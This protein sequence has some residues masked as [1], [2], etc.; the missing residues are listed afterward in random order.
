ISIEEQSFHVKNK[1]ELLCKVPENV[2]DF[3]RESIHDPF[4][5]PLYAYDI[6][7]YYKERESEFKLKKYMECQPDLS[8]SMRAILIDWMVEVQ[9]NFELYHETLYLAIKLVDHYLMRKTVPKFLLQ[10]VGSTALFIACKYDEQRPPLIDDFL[11]ICDDAYSR[12]EL[13]AME[14]NILKELDFNL[15]IPLS[16]RFLRRYAR[17]S[18]NL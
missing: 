10:L 11:Y 17:V 6:F 2:D 15:G 18:I 8:K 14:R 7:K 3:D 5:E 4:C 12:K 1:D 16:Y 9:E 13:I